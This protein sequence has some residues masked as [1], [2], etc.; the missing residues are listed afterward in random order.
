MQSLL[1]PLSGNTLRVW[2][3]LTA[4]VGREPLRPTVSVKD[5]TGSPDGALRGRSYRHDTKLCR[6]AYRSGFE[7]SQPY[8]N[9]GIRVYLSPFDK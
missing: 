6:S 7:S 8:F 4:G 3:L 5:P 9:V 2:C 1:D